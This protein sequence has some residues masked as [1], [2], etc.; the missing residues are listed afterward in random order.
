MTGAAKTFVWR[1]ITSTFAKQRFRLRKARQLVPAAGDKCLR[2]TSN[3][4]HHLDSLLH[5]LEQVSSQKG[6][7]P[8]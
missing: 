5:V 3:R 4:R 7:A 2:R 8:W 1:I 6:D